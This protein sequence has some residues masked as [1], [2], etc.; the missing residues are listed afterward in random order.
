M[1][2]HEHVPHGSKHSRYNKATHK[3]HTNQINN[4]LEK[5]ACIRISQT[6]NKNIT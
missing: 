1:K 6:L 2:I 5:C 3:R 4:Q